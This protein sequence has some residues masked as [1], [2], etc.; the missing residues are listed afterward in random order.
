MKDNR[1]EKILAV[2]KTLY[3]YRRGHRFKSDSS[4]IFSGVFL[5]QS[6]GIDNCE[7]VVLYVVTQ[8]IHMISCAKTSG[9]HICHHENAK[10]YSAI[11]HK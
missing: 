2:G 6:G 3:W 11:H 5:Q 9:S 7:N 4:L 8:V 10:K 1:G